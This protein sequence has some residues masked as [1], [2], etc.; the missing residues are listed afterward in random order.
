MTCEQNESLERENNCPSNWLKM[1][2]EYWDFE[3]VILSSSWKQCFYWED[4]CQF[5]SY[6]FVGY[7]FSSL[8]VLMFLNFITDM[9]SDDLLIF[10]FLPVSSTI[11]NKLSSSS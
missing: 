10:I 11:L 6:S 1:S 3:N 7:F 8:K 9:S 5:N 2:K 4:G